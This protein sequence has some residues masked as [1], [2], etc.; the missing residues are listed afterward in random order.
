MSD[1]QDHGGIVIPMDNPKTG[2][3]RCIWL[4]EGICHDMP[5]LKE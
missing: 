3:P 5:G 1:E 2:V 4:G